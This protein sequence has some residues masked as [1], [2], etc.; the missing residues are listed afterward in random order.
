M[1]TTFCTTHGLGHSDIMPVMCPGNYVVNQMPVLGVRVNLRHLVA[2]WKVEDC[3]SDEQVMYGT[4]FEQKQ[5]IAIPPTYSMMSF[6]SVP[7]YMISSH[8]I[9]DISQCKRLVWL[10]NSWDQGVK[11]YIKSVF[12]FLWIVHGRAVGTDQYD[13]SFILWLNSTL[14]NI[15]MQITG[16]WKFL[17][18]YNTNF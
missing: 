5:T 10:G 9:I 13:F 1:Y 3:V 11:L 15:C 14:M 6:K 12:G 17:K 7:D 18:A 16:S 8:L 4:C 2:V